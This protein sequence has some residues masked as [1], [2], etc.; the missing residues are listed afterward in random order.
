MKKI[1]G[2]LFVFLIS[3]PSAIWAQTENSEPMVVV[4]ESGTIVYNQAGDKIWPMASITKLMTAMVLVDLKLNWNK[5]VTLTRQDERGGARL[6]VAINSNYRRIDLLHASLMGSANNSTYAL[7]RTSGLTLKN[8][9]KRMNKKAAELGMNHTT[10]VDPT[11]IEPK[12]IST[13]EDIAILVEAASRY[14][15]INSIA[16]KEEY[17]LRSIAR[18]PKLHTI[19]ST[20]ALLLA[21]EPVQLGKTGYLIESRYNFAMLTSGPDKNRVVV[22]LNAPSQKASFQIAREFG[23]LGP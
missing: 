22:V 1:I 11:G 19:K 10:F 16:A 14:D 17:T 12:N 20:N 9:V 2:L 21:G 3:W 8:F 6:R 23:K 7:A 13:A 5:T 4:K 15:L 18:K